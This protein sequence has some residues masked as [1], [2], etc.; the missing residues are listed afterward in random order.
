MRNQLVA[1][2]ACVLF[3]PLLTFCAHDSNRSVADVNPAPTSAHEDWQRTSDDVDYGMDPSTPKP[4]A[5]TNTAVVKPVV[6]EPAPAPEPVAVVSAPVVH[7]RCAPIALST[8]AVGQPCM[9]T[10]EFIRSLNL[11]AK[12]TQHALSMVLSADR[13]LAH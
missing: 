7:D 4:F 5:L 1:T 11:G 12:R 3:A 10:V 13:Q 6:V 9:T 2:M 8:A